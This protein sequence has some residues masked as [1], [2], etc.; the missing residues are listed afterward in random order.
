MPRAGWRTGWPRLHSSEASQ[1]AL[2][3][4]GGGAVGAAHAMLRAELPC[5]LVAGW[6]AGWPRLRSSEREGS[7]QL[8]AVAVKQAD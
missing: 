8:R 5:M 1:A 7:C 6:R 4:V 2:Q 3:V